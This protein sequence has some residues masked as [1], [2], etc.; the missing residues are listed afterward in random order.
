MEREGFNQIITYVLIAGLLVLAF[1]IIKPIIFS[2]IYGVLLA[3]I[4]FPFYSWILKKTRSGNFAAF[5]IC[6]GLL[7][8]II[9]LF[10]VIIS[11]LL[12][13]VIDFSVYLRNIDLNEL[14]NK[15]LPDFLVSSGASEEIAG[16]LKTSFSSLLD[17][18]AKSIGNYLVNAPSILLQL[19]VVFFVLFF[20][21]RDGK[22]AFEYMKSI[23][24]FKK[25][26]QEK[27][28]KHFK[29]ITQ[30][31]L[32][33]YIVAGV[34]QGLVAGI[35]YFILGVPN[36][37]FLTILTIIA[38]IIPVVGSWLIWVPVD[39][40]LF[41]TGH[42]WAG[43]ILLIYGTFLISLIDNFIRL[44]I[45]SR[46][47]QINQGIVMIGMIGG[48]FVFGVI[49]LIIGPLILAYVLLVLELY[50]KHTLGESIIFKKCED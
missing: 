47:T 28:F 7:I 50:R 40:Y 25:E 6:I 39:I 27:F 43:I 36:A 18:F 20:A 8:I 33:G 29:E 48:I 49:G 3:Y 31:V 37:I 41:A 11:S 17:S 5:L 45:V 30:S 38:S 12:K 23:I 14:F 1:L 32:I 9:I 44:I 46:K 34:L 16:T 22:E 19:L 24:P 21:L 26:I 2:I 15:T 10:G 13:Q 35:G 4:F 42:F